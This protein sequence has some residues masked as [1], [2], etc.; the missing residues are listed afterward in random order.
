MTPTSPPED[1]VFVSDAPLQANASPRFIVRVGDVH[2]LTLA[3]WKYDPSVR[4]LSDEE[5]RA[6]KEIAASFDESKTHYPAAI[7]E[8]NLKM[9]TFSFTGP[10]PKLPPP[11]PPGGGD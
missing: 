7:F 5:Q 11:P 1:M 4:G 8:D 3:V 6:L 9:K 2:Y 10:V